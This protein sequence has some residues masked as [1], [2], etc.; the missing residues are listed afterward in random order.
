MQDIIIIII[1]NN[2]SLIVS[3]LNVSLYQAVY[4]DKPLSNRRIFRKN[5]HQL[6]NHIIFSKIQAYLS[7]FS[8]ALYDTIMPRE[9]IMRY[10]IDKSKYCDFKIFQDNKLDERAYFIPFSCADKAKGVDM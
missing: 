5:P 7:G 4:L 8:A 2:L 9:S 10:K 1:S 3:L 6:N